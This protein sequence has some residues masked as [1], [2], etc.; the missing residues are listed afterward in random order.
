METSIFHPAAF[1]LDDKTPDHDEDMSPK[2]IPSQTQFEDSFDDNKSDKETYRGAGSCLEAPKGNDISS[3]ISNDHATS[4]LLEAM[5]ASLDSME[6]SLDQRER[7]LTSLEA[8]LDKAQASLDSMQTSLDKAQ[9]SLDSLEACRVNRMPTLKRMQPEEDTLE[10]DPQTTMNIMNVMNLMTHLKAKIDG[11]RDLCPLAKNIRQLF[12]IFIALVEDWNDYWVQD[13][14]EK[15]THIMEKFDRGTFDQSR[16][17]HNES[18]EPFT[19]QVEHVSESK[20]TNEQ[21]HAP[22]LLNPTYPSWFV[23]ESSDNEKHIRDDDDNDDSDYDYDD[24]KLSNGRKKRKIWRPPVG[25]VD[26]VE[27]RC[28]LEFDSFYE[29]LDQMDILIQGIESCLQCQ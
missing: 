2:Y 15:C 24:N 3:Y 10:K 5:E 8:S 14:V 28:L 12:E 17:L 18:Q 27:K 4:G 20:G 22:K 7:S 23:V 26:L 6:A 11:P 13:Y 16:H 1:S 29:K 9:A 21:E 25:Y 19:I